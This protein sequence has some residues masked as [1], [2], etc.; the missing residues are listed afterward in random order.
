MKQGQ[1]M[2][3]TTQMDI[4]HFK[5]IL[6]DGNEYMGRIIYMLRECDMLETDANS[7]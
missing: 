1:K 4:L 2:V 5:D 7:F 3:Y 6:E